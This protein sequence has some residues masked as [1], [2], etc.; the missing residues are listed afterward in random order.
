[1][2]RA[3]GIELRSRVFGS[4]PGARLALLRAAWPDAVGH[5]LALR[6]E[7]LA[8]EGGALRIRVSDASWRRE[9]HRMRQEILSRLRELAGPLAPHALGFT[10]GPVQT[11]GEVTRSSPPPA[12]PAPTPAP[13]RAVVEGAAA[14]QDPEIRQAFLET[15]ARYLERSARERSGEKV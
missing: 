10:L 1:M 7:V 15:A 4:H 11:R 2:R 9:L 8:L 13:P 12:P 5:G 14:I 6:T 3:S